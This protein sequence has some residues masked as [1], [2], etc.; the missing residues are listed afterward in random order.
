[1]SIFGH[2][3]RFYA[4]SLI[5]SKEAAEEIVSDSFYKLWK[6]RDKVVTESSIRAFLYISTRNACFDFMGTARNRVIRDSESM[7]LLFSTDPDILTKMIHVELIE[8][9]VKEIECLPPQQNKVFRMTYLQEMNAEEISQL[10][11]ISVSNVYFA[12][13][14][15]LSKIR[16]YF[17]GRLSSGY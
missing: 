17:K 1:M 5:R 16:D 10:L 13:S 9:I 14:V 12:R 11:D 15:A 7:D 8:L 6:G 2:S 4:Y 3:L